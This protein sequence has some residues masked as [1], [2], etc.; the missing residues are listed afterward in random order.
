M[1]AGWLKIE[2]LLAAALD[3]PHDARESFLDT[4]CAGDP[5][6]RAEVAALVAASERPGPVDAPVA[7]LTALLADLEDVDAIPQ[8]EPGSRLGPYV[9][10]APLGAGGMGQVYRARDTRL[11]RDVAVKVV[12]PHLQRDPASRQRLEREARVIA[13][14]SHPNILAV[15][16][17]GEHEGVVYVVTE[18]LT[19]RTLRQ[20]FQAGPLDEAT[21][22]DLAAQVACGLGVAHA[23]HIVH[24]DLKPENLFV[25]HEGVVKILD[26]GLAKPHPA[27]SHRKTIPVTAPHVVLGTIGYMSPEQV[28]GDR[29]DARSD[30]FSLGAVLYEAACGTPAFDGPTRSEIAAAILSS[31]RSVPDPARISPALAQTI[32]RC[33]ARA[34]AERY[35][36]AADLAFTL[37]LLAAESTARPV[38]MTALPPA[39]VPVHV[40]LARAA[41]AAAVMAAAILL[42]PMVRTWRTG[43]PE[44]PLMFTVRAP[45]GA[46]FQGITMAPFPA[47]SPDGRRLAFVATSGSQLSMWVQTLGELEARALVR[48]GST[49]FPFWSPDGSFIGF[50]SEQR[51]R[52]VAASADRAPQDLCACDARYGGAWSANGTVIFAGAAGLSRVSSGGGAALPLTRLDQSRG[53]FA[54]RFPVLLPDG[55]RFLYLIRSSRDENRGVYLG[56]LDDPALKRRILADD[57]NVAV[58]PGPDGRE[59]LFFV[60]DRVLL[61]QPFDVTDGTLGSDQIV[62]AQPVVSGESGRFAPFAVGGRS[63]VYRRRSRAR[64]P[65]LWVS[66]AGVREGTIGVADANYQHPSLSADG[67]KVAVMM[68]DAETG[69][70]DI[71]GPGSDAAGERALDER[72]GRRDVP[73][74]DAGWTTGG[75]RIGPQRIMGPLQAIDHGRWGCASFRCTGSGR[76]VSVPHRGEPRRPLSAGRGGQED[77]VAAAPHRRSNARAAVRRMARARVAGRTLAGLRNRRNRRAPGIR[78][79]ISSAC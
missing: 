33:L 44:P 21:L 28:T 55:T 61:A 25:T 31:P 32:V 65:L 63:L 11:E 64:T 66:R 3:L 7:T 42:G 75:V 20:M 6:L 62:V 70:P 56:S 52:K 37:Q 2:S 38:P 27:D 17:I 18:L 13:S 54:H 74:V 51:L 58:A 60:R 30:L 40:W 78:H 76:N 69:K 19:G 29:V 14:F 41:L 10:V 36:S 77:A 49:P 45:R 71:W 12:A 59:Y 53:E 72:S 34:P 46:A 22:I 48:L 16:D 15:H 50:G 57:S 1:T 35:Q 4:V 67:T 26:F 73:A 23:R 79:H 68:G 47:L 24:R 43:S 9:V 8:L 39:R 5:G